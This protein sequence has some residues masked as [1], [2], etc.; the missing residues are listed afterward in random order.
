[1]INVLGTNQVTSLKLYLLCG[2]Q[3]DKAGRASI[4]HINSV[5]YYLD[6]A[7]KQLIGRVVSYM[8][9]VD[10]QLIGRVVYYLD[11]TGK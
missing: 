4:N 10:K 11:T 8:G 7:D 3:L 6:A 9:I 2:F 1:M 5:V